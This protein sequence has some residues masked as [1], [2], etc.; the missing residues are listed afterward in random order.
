MKILELALAAFGPF[1]DLVLD[2]SGG[3]EGLHLVYGPNEAGKSSALRGLRQALF[4]IP[5]QSA[6]DFVHSYAKMRIGLTVRG[7]DGHT[8]QFIRR[9]GNRNTLLAGDGATTLPDNTIQQV[10][11]GL[12][13]SEFRTRFALDHDELVQGGKAILQGGGELG[14]LLFQAGGGLKNLLDIQRELTKQIEDLFKPGGSKPRINAGLAALREANEHKREASLLSTEWTTHEEAR[15]KTV[16]RLE[17]VE[18]HL[19]A[20]QAEKRRLERQ[21]EAFPL[22]SRRRVHELALAQLGDVVLLP[23]AFPESR[24]KASL[25]QESARA[26]RARAAEAIAELDRQIAELIVPEELLAQADAVESLREGLAADRKARR[27]IPAEEAKLRQVLSSAADLVA[28]LLPKE[29]AARAPDA[30]EKSAEQSVLDGLFQEV[31]ATGE[32]L[33]LTRSQKTSIQNLANEWTRL[34]AE[35]SQ[36]QKAICNLTEQLAVGQAELDGL[37]PPRSTE[38]LE[39]ALRQAVDQGDLEGS[40]EA[41]RI[42]LAQA[43]AQAARALAQLP[44]W[45]RTLEDLQAAAVPTAEAVDRFEVEFAQLGKEQEQLRTETK[46]AA[47]EQAEA[48]A[49]L[50]HLRQTS[51]AVLTEDDLMRVRG[52]RDRHWKIIR[53]AWES[54]RLPSP[55]EV[56]EWVDLGGATTLSPQPLADGFEQSITQADSHADRLRRESERV[57]KQAAALATLH[58]TGRKLEYLETEQTRLAQ[59]ARLL[60]ERWKQAWAGLVS[61]PSS[62]REMRGWLLLRKELIRQATDIQILRD[63]VKSLESKLAIH[64]QKLGQHLDELT[65]KR[66]DSDELLASL[67]DR[68]HAELKRLAEI[69]S[70]RRSL[71]E[72]TS[73]LSRQLDSERSRFLA[74]E[75]R[76]AA[77]H[78]QWATALAPLCQTAEITVEQAHELLD[79]ASEL[80]AKL[81]E[82]RDSQARL[83]GLRRE[84][85]Q[86]ASEVRDLC[87]RIAPDLTSSAITDSPSDETTAQELLRRF[88][89]ADEARLSKEALTKQRDAEVA[90]AQQADREHEEANLQLAALCREAR[91]DRVD[92]LPG[93][94]ERSRTARELRNQLKLL[95][96]QIEELCGNDPSDQFRRAA[97]ALDLDRLPDQIQALADEIRQLD[98]ERNELNQ[99]LGREQEILKRMDGSD[100]AAEAAEAAEEQKARL[101]LDVEEYARLRLAAVVLHESIER[102]RRQSQGPVLD[103]AASFFKQLTLGSFESLRIDYDD[104]DQAVLLAVRPGGTDAVG[105]AGLSLG[106]ADQLYLALRLASLETYLEKNDPVPL[107]VDDVLI[108]FDDNRAAAA[109]RALADLSVRTQVILFT[110]HEHVRQLALEC[111]QPDRLVLHDLSGRKIAGIGMEQANGKSR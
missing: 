21:K 57:A 102:Y 89:L 4:G 35:L 64:H 93:A 29:T 2:L 107:I 103:R 54:G 84:A 95:D 33:R 38:S 69:E 75:E 58:K 85:A 22:L 50:E 28:E 88:R 20:I 52:M 62:P 27:A 13:E 72:S 18:N 16:A 63:E 51:G 90:S 42:R 9:K 45:T 8:H 3:H 49:G 70:R 87:R 55:Q 108:Q 24:L 104:H 74:L 97:L 30:A 65:G 81:K 110:H 53:R 10:L 6:D 46:N 41:A 79:Q 60:H 19:A 47:A 73:K 5:G 15:C 82:A 68:A 23:D 78:A 98:Q 71:A 59:N 36:V 44:H 109:L 92:E 86:F 48:E 39:L 34:A 32:K 56:S 17:I 7:R 12:T 111:V 77:W 76:Q 66:S 31:T 25:R 83:A 37:A 105:I 1:T 40:L 80:Q 11:N 61:D 14:T 101:A 91:C 94:E 100:R 106:T 43:E 99:A 67:R 26:A 96:E